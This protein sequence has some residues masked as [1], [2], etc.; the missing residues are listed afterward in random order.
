MIRAIR[1]SRRFSTRHGFTLVELLVVIVIIVVLAALVFVVTKNIRT[2]AY[3]ANAVNT[4]RQMATF[5]TAYSTENNGNIHFLR[6]GGDP[7]VNWVNNSF[8]EELR[9]Y[10]A[11]DATGNN[12]P[13]KRE[14]ERRLAS[15]FNTKDLASMA[16]TVLD[17]SRIYR[18]QSGLPV[19]FAFNRYVRG[20]WG[21]RNGPQPASAFKRIQS[22][23]DPSQTSYYTYGFYSF[24]ESD[25]DVYAPL[26]NTDPG[27]TTN[28]YW[29][30]KNSTPV[31]FL[32]GHLEM[33]A[34]PLPDRRVIAR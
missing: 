33:I 8:W 15:L 6:D 7:Y 13:L 20:S 27:G 28:I 12:A 1:P 34:F 32:D 5:T 2:R 22:F 18:D 11:P 31:V 26:P 4:I 3:E 16:G 21:S 10:F 25:A 24:N 19:P 30:G 29:F 23:D 9:P 14:L 17:G